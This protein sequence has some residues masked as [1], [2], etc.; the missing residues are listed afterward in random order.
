MVDFG[1]PQIA[2]DALARARHVPNPIIDAVE[3]KQSRDLI[4]LAERHQPFQSFVA[5]PNSGD[6]RYAMESLG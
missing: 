4:L 6:F 5:R 1:D 3:L 2:G